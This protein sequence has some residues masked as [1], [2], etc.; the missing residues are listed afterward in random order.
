M[1]EYL[2]AT[3]GYNPTTWQLKG[4]AVACMTFI[5]ACK[6]RLGFLLLPH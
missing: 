1:A 3:G 4:L 6:S 2:F 5:I